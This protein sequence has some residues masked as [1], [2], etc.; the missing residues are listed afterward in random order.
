[1]AAFSEPLLYA[2]NFARLALILNP[3]KQWHSSLI[4]C[5]RKHRVT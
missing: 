3:A 5:R 2:E 1:M 4:L